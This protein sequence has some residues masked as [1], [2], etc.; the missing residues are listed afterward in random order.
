MSTTRIYA[1]FNGLVRG[2]RNPQR[3][4]VVLDTFGSLRDLANAGLVL[5]EGMPLIAV[6]A[7][8][9]DEDLE[10]HGTAQ[11]DHDR[12]WWVVEFDDHG[13][14]YVRAG[15]RNP[16]SEFLCVHC[17][18]PLPVASPEAVF[19]PDAACHSCG[20]SVLAPFAPPRTATTPN[21][22]CRPMQRWTKG[23]HMLERL[24]T[25]LFGKPVAASPADTVQWQQGGLYVTERENGRFV[26]LKILKL[27]AHGVHIRVYSN[28]YPEPPA[29][30]DEA[31]LYMAG[32]DRPDDV[33]MGMGHLP[34]SIASF[35][36]WEARFVQ[37]SSVT[38]EE[39]DGYDIWRDAEGGYF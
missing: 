31:T 1:D 24:R 25:R 29:R 34:I 38:A 23:H 13:V 5:E 27:D 2:V 4:A 33:P 18:A 12:N 21:P 30:I 6:D 26:P 37:P 20:T 8:D 39:L 35:S 10:G 16:D 9:D 17:R 3:T 28:V 32:V 19:M 14:R 15:D 36:G 11:Y 7:S 22:A